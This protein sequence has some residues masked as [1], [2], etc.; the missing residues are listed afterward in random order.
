MGP[1]MHSSWTKRANKPHQKIPRRR[2]QELAVAADVDPKT[3]EALLD[4][5][6]AKTGASRRAEAVLA[7]RLTGEERAALGREAEPPS[8]PSPQGAA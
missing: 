2:R 8:A 6:P 1:R 3:L 7:E 4:G 5:A